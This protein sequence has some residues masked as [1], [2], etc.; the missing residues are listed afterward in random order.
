MAKKRT[1]LQSEIAGIF[2]GVP[3]PKKS[4][5]RSQSDSPAEK[6]VDPAS[7]PSGVS[8]A[9]SP[10]F[11][12]G[13]PSTLMPQPQASVTPAPKKTVEPLPAAPRQKVVEIKAP[14][15]ITKRIPKRISKRRKDKIFAP[16]SGVSSSRQ[17]TGI[18]LLVLFSI[19][20]VIV[21]L[22]PYLTNPGKPAPSRSGG[23]Q[24]NGNS[25]VANVEIDWPVP[26]VYSADLRD[27]MEL[28]SRQRIIVES[29]E[30]IVVRGIVVSEDRKYAVIGINYLQEGGIVP[31]TKIRVNKINPN[32]VEFEEDGKTWT[33]KVEGEKR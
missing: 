15:Q 26:P 25:T 14:E 3:V 16:K 20:L 27:P 18:I 12:G 22:R 32:N 17:K 6:P 19:A 13:T 11:E 8:R 21:L 30:D 33:Q 5:K 24:D 7:K 28:G 23:K 29:S 31:G 9:S 10:R 4:G 2:S 1:G